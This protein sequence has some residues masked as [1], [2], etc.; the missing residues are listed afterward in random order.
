MQKTSTLWRDDSIPWIEEPQE[1]GS[2]IRTPKPGYMQVGIAPNGQAIIHAQPGADP[3]SG[4]AKLLFGEG[5]WHWPDVAAQRP[6]I[7]SYVLECLD[8]L[9]ATETDADGNPIRVIVREKLADRD[10]RPAVSGQ[11]EPKQ[12]AAPGGISGTDALVDP[13]KR[14]PDVGV[15]AVLADNLPPHQWLGESK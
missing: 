8:E 3:P 12:Q 6:D 11:I 15:K 1:D 13:G 7:A 10:A 14:L 5:P 4:K 2:V 9:D